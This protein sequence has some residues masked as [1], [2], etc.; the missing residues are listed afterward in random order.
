M[1]ACRRG[2][3]QFGGLHGPNRRPNLEENGP[4]SVVDHQG[5][6]FTAELDAA[7]DAVTDWQR[8]RGAL[9]A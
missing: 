6:L 3:Q 7:A 9:R 2:D 4:G 1:S 5:T 8:H